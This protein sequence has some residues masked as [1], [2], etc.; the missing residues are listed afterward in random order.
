MNE[1]FQELSATLKEL[2][3]A[4]EEWW[5]KKVEP[6]ARKVFRTGIFLLFIISLIQTLAAAFS[7]ELVAIFSSEKAVAFSDE[8]VKVWFALLPAIG[9]VWALLKYVRYPILTAAVLTNPTPVKDMD[10]V[11]EKIRNFAGYACIGFGIEFLYGI[12]L[13]VV[14][15]S[16]R[17]P[18][19]LLLYPLVLALVFFQ[20]M[21]NAQAKKKLT[22]VILFIATGFT[23]AFYWP[24]GQSKTNDGRPTQ[25]AAAGVQPGQ[26][27]LTKTV[28]QSKFMPEGAFVITIPLLGENVPSQTVDLDKDIPGGWDFSGQGPK[29]A[30]V[31]FADGTVYHLWENVGKRG[32][33]VYYTGPKGQIVTLTCTPPAEQAEKKEVQTAETQNSQPQKIS[34]S[35]KTLNLSALAG[36]YNPHKPSRIFGT[37]IHASYLEPRLTI[38]TPGG[39]EISWGNTAEDKNF[40]LSYT[41]VLYH[42]QFFLLTNLDVGDDVEVIV[43]A[44]SQRNNVL[45]IIVTKGVQDKS[46]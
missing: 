43:D 21:K 11:S 28:V 46:S 41:P 5:D 32:G 45:K 20:A 3:K 37:V 6:E 10:K 12:Y 42:D 22:L 27:T 35:P 4:F 26:M 30:L 2:A 38:Q 40:I 19:A 31:H 29:E 8:K 16:N 33:K 39:K 14:P 25:A 34:S 15:V 1:F 7:G 23:I 24:T 36:L 9:F 13:T 44:N 17:W 18:Y